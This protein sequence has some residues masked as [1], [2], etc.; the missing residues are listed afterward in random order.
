MKLGDPVV[1]TQ[2]VGGWSRPEIPEGT[3]GTII[4]VQPLIARFIVRNRDYEVKLNPGE[5]R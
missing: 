2:R 1:T 5:Y 3:M 4:S